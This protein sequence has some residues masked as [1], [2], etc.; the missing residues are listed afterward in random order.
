MFI[1]SVVWIALKYE[2][3]QWHPFALKLKNNIFKAKKILITDYI[4]IETFNFLLRKTSSDIAQDTLTMFLT[5][6]K[7]EI[8]YND[9]IS[10]LASQQILSKYPILS[11]TDANIIFYTQ[12][13]KDFDIMSFDSGF[14]AVPGITRIF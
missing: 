10:M 9:A 8:L 12:I 13:K 2:K 4:I 11:L 14:D 1:D 6:K 5:S 7:I 3:D